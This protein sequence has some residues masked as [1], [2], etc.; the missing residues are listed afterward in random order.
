MIDES[1]PGNEMQSPAVRRSMPM[2]CAENMRDEPPGSFYAPTANLCWIRNPDRKLLPNEGRKGEYVNPTA[3]Y[4]LWR[5]PYTK[6]PE[7][8]VLVTGKMPC[9][10]S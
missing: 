4:Q 5:S 6:E 8:W 3:L 1:R 10:W 2:P 9:R 7:L